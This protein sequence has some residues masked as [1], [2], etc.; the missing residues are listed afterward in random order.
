MFSDSVIIFGATEMKKY[1]MIRL[2]E[3]ISITGA[4]LPALF[5]ARLANQLDYFHPEHKLP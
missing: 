2:P 4:A 5:H 1:F 3:T